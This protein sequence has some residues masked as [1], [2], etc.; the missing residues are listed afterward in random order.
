MLTAQLL[1]APRYHEAWLGAQRLLSFTDSL[2]RATILSLTINTRRRD[3][4]TRDGE[5]WS[6]VVGVIWEKGGDG[7]AAGAHRFCKR[8]ARY[9]SFSKPWRYGRFITRQEADLSLQTLACMTAAGFPIPLPL[10]PPK[11]QRDVCTDLGFLYNSENTSYQQRSE[12]RGHPYGMGGHWRPS[13]LWL[14]NGVFLPRYLRLTG[15]W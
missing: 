15:Q 7:G 2:K 14:S 5:Y 6:R 3:Q 10:L 9:R 12:H 4:I 1:V 11:F 13:R 8:A